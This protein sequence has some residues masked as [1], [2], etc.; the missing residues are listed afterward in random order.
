MKRSCLQVRDTVTVSHEHLAQRERLVGRGHHMREGIGGQGPPAEG[1]ARGGPTISPQSGHASS[2]GDVSVRAHAH[3]WAC[4]RR[5]RRGEEDGRVGRWG[6]SWMRTVACD[7]GRGRGHGCLPT[8]DPTLD[9]RGRQRGMRGRI[10]VGRRALGASEDLVWLLGWRRLRAWRGWRRLR[11]LLVWRRG[12][13]AHGGDG[14]GC[15]HGRDGGGVGSGS[16]A[17][18]DSRARMDEI[19]RWGWTQSDGGDGGGGMVV[20]GLHYRLKD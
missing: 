8:V 16:G 19:G 4:G 7:S 14:G 10:P 6:G 2:E 15:A 18:R 9:V 1:D 12:G 5:R 13:C 20:P 17:R 11:A 3:G